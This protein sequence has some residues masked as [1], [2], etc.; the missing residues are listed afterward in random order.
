[1]RLRIE[2]KHRRDVLIQSK[3]ESKI[4]KKTEVLNENLNAVTGLPFLLHER[5][6]N[7]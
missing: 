6:Y 3:I 5:N 1:M 4:R 2:Q 7:F